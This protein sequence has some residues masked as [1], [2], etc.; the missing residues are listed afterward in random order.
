MIKKLFIASLLIVVFNFIAG[1][2]QLKGD[3]WIFQV[4]KELYSRQPN[5]WELNIQNYNGGSWNNYGEL[6]TYVQQY[7]SSMRNQ[8]L[9]V[10]AINLANGT[11]VAFFNQNNK[12]IAADLISQDGGSLVASGGGNIALNSGSNLT[13]A[14]ITLKPDLAGVRFGSKYTTLSAGTKVIPTSGKG[15]LIIR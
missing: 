13:K 5:A 11:A 2:Q 9:S 12:L 3:P 15:A 14:G 6:K 10:S 4:Y 1:A 7:Q 8:G